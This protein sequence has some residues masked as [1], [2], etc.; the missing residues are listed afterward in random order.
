MPSR[1]CAGGVA[2]KTGCCQ[3]TAGAPARITYTA[4]DDFFTAR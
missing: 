1:G 4:D 2:P 3:A